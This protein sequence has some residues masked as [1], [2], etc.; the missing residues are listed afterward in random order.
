LKELVVH[1]AH[2]ALNHHHTHQ[3]L[4]EVPVDSVSTVVLL[5][6]S[7]VAMVHH[8]THQVLGEVPV[9]LVSTVVLLAVSVVAMVHHHTHQVL[10]EVPV[11]LVSTVVLLAV[12]VVAMVHHHTNPQ[13]TDQVELVVLLVLMLLLPHLTVPTRTKMAVLMLMNSN[14][15]TKAVYKQN[16]LPFLFFTHFF[17]LI[18]LY[19]S[20]SF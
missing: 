13:L 1:M 17:T 15:S 16:K 10:G 7:V 11:D 4:E 3:V 6:V 5:A 9:D 19:F 8:H 18:V 12:S 20:F 2:Q 14:N